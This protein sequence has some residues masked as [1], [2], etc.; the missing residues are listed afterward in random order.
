MESEFFPTECT[1]RKDMIIQQK[2]VQN[3][4]ISASKSDS[5]LHSTLKHL[6]LQNKSHD[7]TF[8]CSSWINK[9]HRLRNNVRNRYGAGEGLEEDPEASAG[10]WMA[11]YANA[12]RSCA[13]YIYMLGNFA[14]LRACPGGPQ[15]SSYFLLCDI[16]N[17]AHYW[18]TA[19]SLSSCS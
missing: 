7:S 16:L 18:N 8:S 2:R 6:S 10:C 15:G 12:G 5:N 3:K 19:L 4:Q 11:A 9:H 1:V 13:C 14:C 17:Y